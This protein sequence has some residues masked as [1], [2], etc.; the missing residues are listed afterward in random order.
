MSLREVGKCFL[1]MDSSYTWSCKAVNSIFNL[2]IKGSLLYATCSFLYVFLQACT[3]VEQS[4]EFLDQMDKLRRVCLF[5]FV[6][7]KSSR[8]VEHILCM[9]S[10]PRAQ[11]VYC[12]SIIIMY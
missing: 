7:S 3:L 4:I 8:S 2:G 10:R 5:Y 6:L 11:H 9:Y 1:A 12:A